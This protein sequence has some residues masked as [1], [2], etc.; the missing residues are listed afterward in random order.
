MASNPY[1][2]SSRR[3]PFS[4]VVDKKFILFGGRNV[5]NQLFLESYDALTELWSPLKATGSPTPP[6]LCEG[7]SASHKSLLFMFGGQVLSSH[8]NSLYQLDLKNNK[9]SKLR[10]KSTA[11]PMKKS[12]CGMISYNNKLLIFGG[13][14]DPSYPIQPGSELVK[15]YDHY[16][17][18]E[19]HTFDLEGGKVILNICTERNN[20]DRL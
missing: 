20:V 2:P 13:R 8:Q 7:A 9:L 18:N 1:E 15:H 10:S 14:C 16:Y 5:K 12:G 3:Y 11:S 4:S 17:T 6:K 19:L